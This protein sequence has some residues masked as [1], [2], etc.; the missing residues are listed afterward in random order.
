MKKALIWLLVFA[1][2]ESCD[3]KKKYSEDIF[4]L[5][6][7]VGVHKD[8]SIGNR[9]GDKILEMKNGPTFYWT[10]LQFDSITFSYRI[11]D[12][13]DS[14]DCLLVKRILGLPI[15]FKTSSVKDSL[16]KRINFIIKNTGKAGII[17][18]NC[19]SETHCFSCRFWYKI[20]KGIALIND[21]KCIENFKVLYREE[22]WVVVEAK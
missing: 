7:I 1:L 14:T 22:N 11:E 18:S 9:G 15:Y 13:L 5:K 12:D 6:R 16:E 3:S 20:D 4:L 21:S 10:K 17:A 8:I 19:L 2:L